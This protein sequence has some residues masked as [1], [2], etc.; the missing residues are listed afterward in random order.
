MSKNEILSEL[1]KLSRQDRDEIR[2]RLTE[3]DDELT[4]EEEALIEER[5][6]DLDKNPQLSIPWSEAEARLKARYGE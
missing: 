3:L 1:E 4:P 2:A 6:A 5:M